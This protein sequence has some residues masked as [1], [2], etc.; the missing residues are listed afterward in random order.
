MSWEYELAREI[1][2]PAGGGSPALLR[3]TVVKTE[4]LTISLCGGE[5]MAPPM[6]LE[7]VSSARGVWTRG[8]RVVCGLDGQTVIILGRLGG[9][10]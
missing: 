10:A 8:E 7:C 6:A 5:V 2:R 3:G 1:K 4:P 9:S